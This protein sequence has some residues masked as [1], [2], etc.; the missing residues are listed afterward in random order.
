M[1]K[2]YVC[3]GILAV[4]LLVRPQVGEAR[5]SLSDF[6][7]IT[8]D[9]SQTVSGVVKDSDGNSIPGV[10]IVVKGTSTGTITDSE[11]KYSLSVPDANSVLVFS[12]IGYS[13]QEVTLSGRS[14]IDVSMANDVKALEEVVVTALG[15]ERS[16][17]SLGY[18][19]SKV[20]AEQ[21]V[22]SLGPISELTA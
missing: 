2:L 22:D 1:R 9:Q 17:K 5:D 14:T 15:I 13:Q 10:N 11:G 12:F 6:N 20:N 3:I 16:S 8:D 19:T 4:C 7:A 21:F 18:A